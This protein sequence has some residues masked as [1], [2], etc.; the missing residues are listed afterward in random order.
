MS[1]FRGLA[2]SAIFLLTLSVPIYALKAIP[3]ALIESN[4]ATAQGVF[5]SKKIIHVEGRNT[6]YY[7]CDVAYS[8][9]YKG[10]TYQGY[11]LNLDQVQPSTYREAEGSCS[12]Y[13]PGAH[14]NVFLDK[15]RPTFAVLDKANLKRNLIIFLIM[16]ISDVMLIV[17]FV[18]NK[19]R[20]KEKFVFIPKIRGSR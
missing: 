15:N 4:T 1:F 9:K 17:L 13:Y 20:N 19:I 11:R 8:Y 6:H 3:S 18:A 12:T 14:I 10:R 16:L 7:S 5:Y 2:L